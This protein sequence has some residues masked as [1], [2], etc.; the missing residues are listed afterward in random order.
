M[1]LKIVFIGLMALPIVFSQDISLEKWPDFKT[2]WKVDPAKKM[3][4]NLPPNSH[5]LH[6]QPKTQKE[7]ESENWA[8]IPNEG[9]IDT[10]TGFKGFRFVPPWNDPE[11]IVIYDKNG[12]IAGMQSI[13]PKALTANS[14]YKFESSPWYKEDTVNGIKVYLTTAYFTNPNNICLTGRT[15]DAFDGEGTG[16]ILW[17]L[18][19]NGNFHEAPLTIGQADQDCFWN[20][21]KCFMTMG[22]HYFNFG[23]DENADICEELTPFQLMYI[24]NK[25]NGFVW[26]H[27]APLTGEKWEVTVIKAVYMSINK[28]PKCLLEEVKKKM[29]RSMHVFLRGNEI[30]PKS[31]EAEDKK[32]GKAPSKPNCSRINY[33]DAAIFFLSNILFLLPH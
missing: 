14:N 15:Q 27:N 13:V 6:K 26:Q 20:R 19:N 10:K 21:H 7:A 28:P 17:F 30:S 4:H 1:P 18:K 23:Y 2:T 8:L 33:L 32:I 9:C 16:N 12:F 3:P 29:A 31:C 24:D 25:L 22:V 11:F 5:S